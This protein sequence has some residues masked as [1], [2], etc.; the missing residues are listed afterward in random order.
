MAYVVNLTSRAERDLAHLY[1]EIEAEHSAAALKWYRGLKETIL[2]LE[3][4]P[5]RCARTRENANF[6][7]LLYGHKPHVYRV[8]YRV[9]EG[10]KRLDVL[11]I[12]HG[13]RRKFRAPDLR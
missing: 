3:T 5:N 10:R 9:L 1:E 4:Y 11:H 13:A 6:R 12:R 7:H 2:S 8:I